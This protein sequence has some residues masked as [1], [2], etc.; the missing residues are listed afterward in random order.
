MRVRIPLVPLH[1]SGPSSKGKTASSLLADEGS[2]PSGSTHIGHVAQEQSTLA[3]NRVAAG[4]SPALPTDRMTL[5]ASATRGLQSR[6][7]GG[8]THQRLQHPPGLPDTPSCF[9]HERP[10]SIP[11][12]GAR[13]RHGWALHERANCA[14]NAGPERAVGVQVP[15]HPPSACSS[16]SRAPGLGPGGRG[17]EARH[18]DRTGPHPPRLSEDRR[19]PNANV[20]GSTPGAG[21]SH[22]G[23][24]RDRQVS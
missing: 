6:A 9:Y 1:R 23:G 11:G 12:A 16:A 22:R 3:D 7:R 24:L 8:S 10:G 5:F 17:S 13:V 2:T 4:A 20:P 19:G 15:P 18:A 21:A 14:V